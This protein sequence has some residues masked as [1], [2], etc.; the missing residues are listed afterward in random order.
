MCW[1]VDSCARLF[2]SEKAVPHYER[3]HQEIHFI[4]FRADFWKSLW[5]KIKDRDSV[6]FTAKSLDLIR[7]YEQA[8]ERHTS[9]CV[10][11][12]VLRLLSEVIPG[13]QLC[14]TLFRVVKHFVVSA[15]CVCVSV[16]V[17]WFLVF[18]GHSTAVLT[19]KLGHSDIKTN[20]K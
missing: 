9:T 16:F 20:K 19:S 10:A 4:L 2:G 15:L 18:F 17:F 14:L 8:T 1:I 11:V 6:R 5:S 13:R 7:P 12:L 3:L